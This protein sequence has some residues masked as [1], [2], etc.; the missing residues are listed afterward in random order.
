MKITP[1]KVRTV[2]RKAGYDKAQWHASGQI[3]GWG[4]W[5]EGYQVRVEGDNI[6]VVHEMGLYW[7]RNDKEDKRRLEALNRYRQTL[8]EAG[9]SSVIDKADFP[10]LKIAAQP[11]T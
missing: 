2:L 11:S 6:I 10:V 5:S 1:Q 8:Q 3:R 4:E 9:I 7:T